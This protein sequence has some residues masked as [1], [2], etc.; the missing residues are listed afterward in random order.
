ME[1]G[2]SKRHTLPFS[3]LCQMTIGERL[4]RTPVLQHAPLPSAVLGLWVHARS[5]LDAE[6]LLKVKLRRGNRKTSL[7]LSLCQKLT[8]F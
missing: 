4:S 2:L 3:V 6:T 7:P 1:A 5:S 8:H